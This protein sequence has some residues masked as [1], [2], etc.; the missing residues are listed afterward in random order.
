MGEDD[1]PARAATRLKDPVSP[2]CRVRSDLDGCHLVVRDA[3]ALGRGRQH[4]PTSVG[5]VD[6]D[7]RL[8]NGRRLPLGRRE[9]SAARNRD[10]G[11]DESEGGWPP[12]GKRHVLS[13]DMR[14]A[15]VER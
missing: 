11:Q 7:A 4:R 3:E 5:R 13:V 15:A 12:Q 6:R 10:A 9:E 8:S 1:D 2:G 14:R